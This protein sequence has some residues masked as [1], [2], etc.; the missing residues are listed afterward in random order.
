M[1]GTGILLAA[2]LASATPSASEA[3][4]RRLA[5]IAGANDGGVQ[6]ARLRYADSDAQSVA[7]VLRDLGGFAEADTVVLSEPKV[8]SLRG[9]LADIGRLAASDQAARRVEL[10]VYYS[11]HSDEA[12]LLL[13]DERYTYTD[14]RADLDALPVDVHIA[15][16]DSCSSGSMVLGK[17]GT[18]VPAFLMDESSTIAGHA[19]LT[20]SSA[21]E[22]SQEAGRVGGSFFTHALVTGLRG[23]ADVDRDQRVT[24]QE[25][26][27]FAHTETLARTEAT[28]RGSQHPQYELDIIGA[29]D[30]VLTD[31]SA[32]TSGLTL[33][34]DLAGRVHLW[35]ADG[36]L[37]AELF[38]PA[39]RAIEMGLAPGRYRVVVDKEGSF[40]EGHVELTQGEM[41]AVDPASWRRMRT[42]E[43]QSRGA[44]LRD[45]AVTLQYWP[46]ARDALRRDHAALG[47]VTGSAA[48]GGASLGVV[49]SS[50]TG[51]VTGVQL[52]SA[53]TASGGDLRGWQGSAAVA[54]AQRVDGVQTSIVTRA[55]DLNG[56]QL[57]VINSSRS[58]NGV[59]I[60]L[61]NVSGGGGGLPIGL[62]NV[63]K[64]GIFEID[65]WSSDLSLV[66]VGVKSGTRSFY[67]LF[68][69]GIDPFDDAG[70]SS[71]GGALGVRALATGPVTV[72]VELFGMAHFPS[73]LH[74][75]T[76]V[77]TPAL[78]AQ[79]GMKLY[80]RVGV[81]AGVS[82][83]G[84]LS[85]QD[86]SL[87]VT[88][89]PTWILPVNPHGALRVYPGWHAGVTF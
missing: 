16:L 77:A 25:A 82:L 14:L 20:S 3:P 44:G 64:D 21:D 29:G 66:N 31:L 30:L 71:A 51:N 84:Q 19:F 38:K 53:V 46:T 13:G 9:A 55:T 32:T 61:I 12:G 28:L 47:L 18:R 5:L 63:V 36:K 6:R 10:I 74:G 33:P 56:L 11:G 17:G 73:F 24:L 23:A 70:S 42:T 67:T 26:Y 81:F 75:D 34:I 7:E 76:V 27:D 80:E 40:F 79:A 57:G 88:Q 1:I 62:L 65:V 69:V 37:A 35:D 85:M 45:R 48:L 78:R 39:G 89:M 58:L 68:A 50:Y 49:G 8:G 2:T 72:D 52:A 43:T 83:G 4:I 59:A 15:I 87:T 54:T 60:G 22:A 41:V 86:P